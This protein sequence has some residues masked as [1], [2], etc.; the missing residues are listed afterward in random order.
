MLQGGQR[1]LVHF[2]GSLITAL[3]DTYAEVYFDE[4]KFSFTKSMFAPALTSSF[5]SPYRYS[6]DKQ[7]ATGPTNPREESSS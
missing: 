4:T 2:N 3:G 5:R 6:D 1:C 7:R